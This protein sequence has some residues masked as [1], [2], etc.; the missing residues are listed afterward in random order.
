MFGSNKQNIWYNNNDY[1]ESKIYY[2]NDKNNYLILYLQ[3][4]IAIVFGK[5]NILKLNIHNYNSNIFIISMDVKEMNLDIM[6]NR[7]EILK[8]SLI[9][10]ENDFAV[11]N[12]SYR[13]SCHFSIVVPFNFPIKPEYIA[14][15]SDIQAKL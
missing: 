12:R 8:K 13:T 5:H 11:F 3:N 15:I 9:I 7:F 4:R 14:N 2:K 10:P 6:K 1:I